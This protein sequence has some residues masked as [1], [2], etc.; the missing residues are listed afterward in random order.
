MSLN[1]CGII[2]PFSVATVVVADNYIDTFPHPQGLVVYLKRLFAQLDIEVLSSDRPY[3]I[4]SSWITIFKM[5]AFLKTLLATLQSAYSRGAVLDEIDF[6]AAL[7]HFKE[8]NNFVDDRCSSEKTKIY[9][10]PNNFSQIHSSS[11][12]EPEPNLENNTVL[13]SKPVKQSST[14]NK[15]LD[16]WYFNSNLRGKTVDK[17]RRQISASCKSPPEPYVIVE[18]EESNKMRQPSVIE[19][20]EALCQVY[21]KETIEKYHKKY[22]NHDSGNN[23][24]PKDDLNENSDTKV[25]DHKLSNT[26]TLVDIKTSFLINPPKKLKTTNMRK[27]EKVTYLRKRRLKNKIV[28]DS[29]LPRK[30]CAKIE[31]SMSFSRAPDNERRQSLR[32]KCK[33]R[34]ENFESVSGKIKRKTKKDPD[35][36]GKN[37]G[38]CLKINK[39]IKTASSKNRIKN[40]NEGN[41]EKYK[42][43]IQPNKSEKFSPFKHE[44]LMEPENNVPPSN[45]SL[46]QIQNKDSSE[47][48]NQIKREI[49]DAV[50]GT[51][52]TSNT[53][54]SGLIYNCDKCLYETSKSTQLVEHQ[55]RVHLTKKFTCEIC[56]K[57]FGYRKDLRRHMKCH[58]EAENC[59][60]VC[61]KLYKEARQLLD[62]KKSHAEDYI[63]PE[64]P[65]KFCSKIFSTKYVLAYHIKSNHL[66]MKRLYMC[67]SCGKSFS[68]KKSYLQHANV[69]MGIRPFVCE[70][71]GKKF[72][73]VKSLNQHMYMHK[74][75]KL[76]PCKLCDKSFRQSS[77]LA[78]HLKVHKTTKDYVCSMCGKGFS[79]RQA[80]TRHERIHVGE[81]PFECGLCRR[82]FADSSVLRRHMIQIHKKDPKKWREDTI[83]HRLKKTDFYINVISNANSDTLDHYDPI[84]QGAAGELTAMMQQNIDQP[85]DKSQQICLSGH[86]QQLGDVHRDVEHYISVSMLSGDSATETTV[87]D[88]QVYTNF[89][90]ARTSNEQYNS[91]HDINTQTNIQPQVLQAGCN[92]SAVNPMFTPQQ[93]A[94]Q[95]NLA[96]SALENINMAQ[97]TDSIVPPQQSVHTQNT[98]V[99]VGY[100]Q[101]HFTYDPSM[102]NPGEPQQMQYATV[103]CQPCPQTIVV[104]QKNASSVAYQT[105]GV[106]VTYHNSSVNNLLS[107][108]HSS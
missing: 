89:Y 37:G 50:P 82:T 17:T 53:N 60:D 12:L 4:K 79:Q 88:E 24:I 61:G 58:T 43:T 81:K 16:K 20:E 10:S 84:N 45:N 14:N 18:A 108:D 55:R 9:C 22:A 101:R 56:T 41:S 85:T 7:A 69:H 5:D 13:S 107:G 67:P 25:K 3:T 64:F 63:K 54:T 94:V 27:Q 105:P 66:G 86:H 103:M 95:E 2:S 93:F 99:P 96:P 26:K 38:H 52:K 75:E 102:I 57:E 15:L 72:S 65:C 19:I 44:G 40:S 87:K 42:A 78:T 97:S 92:L 36:D 46:T 11:S 21:K 83:S 90:K 49:S 77:G 80:M 33:K 51:D 70:V 32:Q 8:T 48:I 59:C 73:Y 28:N 74:E 91:F 71:C 29:E 100:T 39:T 76:F 1:D 31:I 68:Q 47:E 35:A 34:S 62:H 30:S 104:L 23:L 98:F 106:N 6:N